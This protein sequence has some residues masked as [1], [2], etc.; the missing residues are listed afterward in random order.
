MKDPGTKMPD[1][2]LQRYFRRK[3]SPRQEM[4]VKYWLLAGCVLIWFMVLSGGITRLTHSGLS[5]VNWNF[6]LGSFPPLTEADWQVPFG[7]Y[8]TSPEFRLINHSFG[9]EEFKRIYWWEYW[10]RFTGRFTGLFFII[11]FAGFLWKG[12]F[13]LQRFRQASFLLLLGMLQGFIG[14][15]MVKSGLDHRPHVSHFRLAL[16]LGNAFLLFFF[17]FSFF[18]A[19]E[20]SHSVKGRAGNSLA[21]LLGLLFGQI[22]LGAFVS[23][24]KA[25][26][27]YNTY[28]LMGDA[29]IPEEIP[30]LLTN[31]GTIFSHGMSVQFL[32]RMM[33]LLILAQ[34]GK[35]LYETRRMTG[36]KKERMFFG[37]MVLIQFSLGVTALLMHVPVIPGVL[38]Q[39]GAF[40]LLSSVVLLKRNL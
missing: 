19:K 34:S 33:A 40:L 9:L 7:Q 22:I 24:L 17:A 14:W 27:I 18:L 12:A 32:H 31:A 1:P 39:A 16:H 38:H 4:L 8:K 25:G 37:A 10:H 28:P 3:P 2:F 15:F 26:L 13:T 6:I 23:G 21:V 5:M 35:I 36:I 11:P 30:G 20:K 29:F